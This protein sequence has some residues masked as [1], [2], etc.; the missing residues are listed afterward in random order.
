M[1]NIISI[2]EIRIKTAL[3]E[4]EEA[5]SRAKTM[6]IEGEEVPEDIIPRLEAIVANLEEKLIKLIEDDH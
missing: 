6:V 3:K 5:L 2:G 1:D 4:A